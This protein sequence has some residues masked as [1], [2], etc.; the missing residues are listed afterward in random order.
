MLANRTGGKITDSASLER[1][2]DNPDASLVQFV[3]QLSVASKGGAGSVIAGGLDKGAGSVLGSLTN[4]DPAFSVS[5]WSIGASGKLTLSVGGHDQLLEVDLFRLDSTGLRL[6]GTNIETLEAANEAVDQID[7]AIDNV[8][9]MRSHYGAIQNRLEHTLA[10]L[11]NTIEN[12]TAAE[13]RIR[14]TD[15]AFA[16]T[17]HVRNQILM[18]SGQSMLAQAN[19][20]PENILSLLSV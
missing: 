18:Q 14:D 1:L 3:R 4:L 5:K 8:S 12:I 6:G 10:N 13:S 15:M 20:I 17:E 7:A 9:K 16:L 11:S 2:F 19:R